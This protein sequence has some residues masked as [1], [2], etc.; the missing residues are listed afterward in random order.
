MQTKLILFSPELEMLAGER[1]KCF[2][3]ASKDLWSQFQWW[4]AVDGI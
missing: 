1:K 4:K 2:L 3:M